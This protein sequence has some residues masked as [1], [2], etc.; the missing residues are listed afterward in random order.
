MGLP[1]RCLQT[2]HQIMFPKCQYSI[3]LYKYIMVSICCSHIPLNAPRKVLS[4]PVSSGCKSPIQTIFM[5]SRALDTEN[6]PF[7]VNVS[8]KYSQQ[9]GNN[10]CDHDMEITDIKLL[11]HSFYPY[12]FSACA[13][14]TTP[15]WARCALA[16]ANIF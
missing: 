4:N 7:L 15:S 10:Y 14:E 8:Q 5:S 2:K 3:S 1:I 11:E 12:H 6:F 13:S 9:C 16:T